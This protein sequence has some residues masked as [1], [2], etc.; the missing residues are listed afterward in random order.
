MDDEEE[1]SDQEPVS[2]QSA[3]TEHEP[4]ETETPEE[5]EVVAE[6]PAEMEDENEKNPDISITPDISYGKEAITAQMKQAEAEAQLAR[7]V[8]RIGTDEVEEEES[9]LGKTRVL[10]SIRR[11]P[12]AE[13]GQ[14][15]TAKQETE[16]EDDEP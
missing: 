16:P 3:V 12:A 2:G 7:E 9:D 14:N 11:M 1:S 5:S 10:D 6:E 15:V 8:S 4:E 13:A